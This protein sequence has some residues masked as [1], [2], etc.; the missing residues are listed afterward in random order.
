M[1]C[2]H[3]A[4]RKTPQTPS[5]PEALRV[6]FTLL[7]LLLVALL[8]IALA[9]PYFIDWT[10]QRKQIEAQLSRVLGARVEVAGPIDLKLLPVPF[11]TLAKVH[12]AETGGGGATLDSDN[13]RLEMALAALI[14]GQ[15]RFTQASFNHPVLTIV[16]DPAGGFVPLRFGAKARSD[17]VALEKVLVRDGRI[18]AAS[19]AG[20]PAF[21]IA[22]IDLDA[23]ADSL[24]GPFKGAGAAN[25]P[26]GGRVSFHFASGI[27]RDGALPAKGSFE[28]AD[29]SL[30]GEFDGVASFAPVGADAKALA[31]SY[32]GAAHLAGSAALDDEASRA[33]WSF[34]GTA[35]A[36][37]RGA[38]LSNLE[39][40]FGEEQRALIATGSANATFREKPALSINLA[41]KKLDLDA[42]LRRQDEGSAAP[43]R[44]LDLA[45]RLAARAGGGKDTPFDL[46]FDLA[47]P[48]AILGGDTISDISLHT[49]VGPHS[50]IIARLE[51]GPPGRS[52]LIASGIVELGAAEGFKGRVDAQIGDAQALRDWSTQDAE[53]LRASLAAL[54]DVLPYRSLAFG[55]DVDLS[56]AGFAVRNLR[57]A[58]EQSVFEGTLAWTGAMG[59]ERSRLFMDLRSDALDLAS[60]PNLGAGG[61]YFR[62][63]DL[64]LRLE[65]KA[66]R[67]ERIADTSVSGGQLAVKVT[68]SG[69]AMNV[70]R[71]AIKGLGGA[72]V[73]AKGGAD[74]SGSWIGGRVEAAQLHDFAALARRLAPGAA[75][76]FLVD[77]S[78]ALSPASLTFKAQFS[79]DSARA[80][81]PN[82][83]TLSGSAGA[84][85]IEARIG[86]GAADPG[87]L[88][89]SF[90]LNAPETA[91]LLRQLGA[92]AQSLSGKGRGQFSLTAR[93]RAAE[94]FDAEAAASLSGVD[95]S[96]VGASIRAAATTCA[97]CFPAPAASRAPMSLPCCRCLASRRRTPRSS[98]PR[99][100]TRTLSGATGP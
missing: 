43:A 95:S 63:S 15:F 65:A 12:V 55:G 21:N 61:D 85:Q 35:E 83:L 54:G 74:A 28:A 81:T 16:R 45:R 20:A 62:D 4:A 9:A 17:Q 2:A 23:E 11:L 50:P 51:C 70:D 66:L 22:G 6:A 69:D 94:G 88:E 26:G 10:A 7:A 72:D 100:S 38:Q 68:K 84:T 34:S 57:L 89:A 31:L 13:I 56:N 97:P 90:T 92:P 91:P 59:N 58:A 93:G 49:Q 99:H 1:N 60:L 24:R 96:G 79:F 86:R 27:L 30:R 33:P 25:G 3:V 29:A 75:S 52:H 71:L 53:P 39:V 82:S 37:E 44:A 73:E 47:S 19:A 40:R 18:S 76:D 5:R 64:E 77:R 78:S 67:V 48:S 8:S 46:S 14:R 32:S 80:M 36:D 98:C 41:S 42:M 87:A